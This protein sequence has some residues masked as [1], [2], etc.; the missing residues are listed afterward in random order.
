M[1]FNKS[2]VSRGVV[3]GE[4]E[5]LEGSNVQASAP[6]QDYDPRTLFER[7]QEQRNIKD[8]EFHE[9]TRLSNLIKLVDADEAEFY[10]T[11]SDEQK[12]LDEKRKMKEK[13]ELET[14]R[15]AVEQARLTAP[16]PPTLTATVTTAS[17]TMTPTSLKTT[18]RKSTASPF[19]GLVVKKKKVDGQEE[20]SKAKKEAPNPNPNPKS[21]PKSN[22][23]DSK[24]KETLNP[25]GSLVAYSD[26]SSDED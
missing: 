18:K 6:I 9:A 17:V 3:D 1:A 21:N 4:E 22:T 2:F 12:S 20:D 5:K 11:L 24:P 26:Y 13:D 16:P 14:Y 23:A 10:K 19:Q 7:L 25:L 15:K 8:E